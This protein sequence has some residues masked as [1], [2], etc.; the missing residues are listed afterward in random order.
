MVLVS[1]ENLSKSY[2]E[3]VLFKNISFSIN[4]GEKIGLIGVNGTGKS[5][6]L[7][8]L[9]GEDIYDEGRII[10]AGNLSIGYLPQ[11]PSF[12]SGSTVLEQVFK[13]N[14]PVMSLIREYEDT[15]SLV[16]SSMEEDAH[17]K[18][19]NL[20]DRMD[21]A[22]AWKI[23]S[24]AKAV[25]T[26]LG[27][28]EFNTRIG[29]LS[30]GMKRRIALAGAL[31]SPSDL[32]ILDEPTNHIDSGTIS[33]LEEYLAKYKG[34]ILM[35]THDR[36]FLDRVTNRIM[37]FDG[38]NLYNYTGNY[39]VFIEKKIERQE[40]A[41]SE[42]EKR[43]NLLRKELA[44]VKRGAKARSTKQKARLQRFDEL[45]SKT[46]EENDDTVEISVSFSRLGK[47]IIEL[48]HISKSFSGNKLINDFNYIIL[49]NDRI[50]IIGPNGIGKTTLLNIISGAAAPDSGTVDVGQTVKVGFY[51]QEIEDMDTDKRVIDYIKETAEY[52]TTAGGEELSAS[53]MLEKFLFSPTAQW[54]PISK[55][56]G[57][58]RKRLYLLKVLIGA[59]NVLLLD[60]PTNDLDIETLTVLEDYLDDFNGAVVT[61]SHDR[62]FLDRVVDKVFIFGKDGIINECT[63][64]YSACEEYIR[65]CSIEEAAEDIKKVE[66]PWKEKSGSEGNPRPVKFTFKEKKEYEAI[67]DVI[68]GLEK[69]LQD[70][71]DKISGAGSDYVLLQSLLRDQGE[72]EDKL[73]AVMERWVY[74]NELAEKIENS[75]SR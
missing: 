6:L 58:E 46:F 40:Y 32:L 35:V 64:N 61:V 3:K 8:V 7:K 49:R 66:K 25:L 18:L 19:I 67:D 36:Y 73:N 11:N 12:D 15:L 60:E 9:A 65:E 69:K 44:W 43:Q 20:N 70:I 62:Y 24:D 72:T 47:K 22:G 33:W 51:S 34:A 75:K 21:A 29:E 53:Q 13:G 1:A 45:S 71:K 42:E 38:G 54:T 27:L 31:I 39:S 56:S 68:S 10:K 28:T 55:L 17:K 26:K 63:G 52:I 16:E 41:R 4:E 37:E 48:N 57:G 30:G 14:S 2:G 50:G 23:E 5:T 59:P 74:L